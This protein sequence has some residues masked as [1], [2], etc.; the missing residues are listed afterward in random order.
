MTKSCIAIL[1]GTFNEGGQLTSEFEEYSRRSNANGEAHNGK[2]LGKYPISAN[3]GQGNA[4]HVVFVVEF[5]SRE[6]AEK[7]FTN[8]EYL[9]II[10]LRDVAFQEVKIL[11]SDS[12]N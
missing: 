12:G 2:L 3:L 4:P 7:A 1:E 5:P 11:L 6:I 9:A 8:S 10:P